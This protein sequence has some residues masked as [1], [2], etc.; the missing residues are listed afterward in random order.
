MRDEVLIEVDNLTKKFSTSFKKSAKKGLMKAVNSFFGK[1][2]SLGGLLAGEFFAIEAVSLKVKRG[3]TV[4]LLGKNGAGK[5]TL[6][7]HISGIYL[8]DS[9]SVKVSGHV[10]GLIELGAGFHPMLSGRENIKQ[11]VAMLGLSKKEIIRL[12]REIIDFSEL[13]EFIDMPLKNYSSGMQAR[14]G[15]ASAVLTKPDVLLVDE[16]LSVGDFE[17]KQ[18]CLNKINEIKQDAAIIFVSHSM[19]TMSM[20]CDRGIVF[21]KGKVVNDSDIL[22]A[23]KFYSQ[24][25]T[26]NKKNDGDI[27]QDSFRGEEYINEDL[28]KSYSIKYVDYD[29]NPTSNYFDDDVFL[30][31]NIEFEKLAEGISC[32]LGIPIWTESGVKITAINLDKDG[33]FMTVKDSRVSVVIKIDN[34]FNSSTLLS[35]LAVHNST[36][37][38]LRKK[39]PAFTVKKYHPREDGL[40]TL[41]YEVIL[42]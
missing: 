33:S 26:L 17:F 35:C 21:K 27:P 23:I 13:E 28:V 18:K 29:G 19:Q 11:R 4:G 37:Y 31:I 20:F 12:T 15:F 39:L 14:L 32:T 5:S 34:C 1:K 36:E 7:K 3:E 24:D 30:S 9:G 25:E 2:S 38:L 10:E 8:P 42:E 22:E 16:V 6:L 40:V 41:N